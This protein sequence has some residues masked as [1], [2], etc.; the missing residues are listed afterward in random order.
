MAG[1]LDY[2]TRDYSSEELREDG[3][4]GMRRTDTC[5]YCMVELKRALARTL[6][7]V[8]ANVTTW[9]RESLP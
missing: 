8:R 4:G 5:L 9:Y 2:D 1:I 3:Q 7:G 6:S